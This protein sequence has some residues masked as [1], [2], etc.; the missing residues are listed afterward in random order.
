MLKENTKG[1]EEKG[2]ITVKQILIIVKEILEAKDRS[3]AGKTV[4]PSGLCLMGVEYE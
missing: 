2:N 3:R 4:S 1:K